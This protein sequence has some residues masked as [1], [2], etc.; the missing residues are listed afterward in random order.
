MFLC[1]HAVLPLNL[2]VPAT[3]HGGANV[4][5]FAFNLK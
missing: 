3:E 5:A 4:V 1:L 2:C